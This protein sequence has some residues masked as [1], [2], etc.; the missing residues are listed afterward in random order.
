LP[1]R[2][3]AEASERRPAALLY[4]RNAEPLHPHSRNAGAAMLPSPHDRDRRSVMR[5]DVCRGYL[6]EGAAVL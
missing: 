2:R 1:K 4:L 3:T 6:R 5:D